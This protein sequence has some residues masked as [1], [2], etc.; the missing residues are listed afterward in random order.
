MRYLRLKI[1]IVE[2]VYFCYTYRVIKVRIDEV[3]EQRGKTR[4]WLAKATSLTQGTIAKLAKGQTTGIDFATLS[5]ICDALSCQTSDVLVA[6]RD[7]NKRK[8]SD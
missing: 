8:D 5:A 2:L 1:C 7:K 4:Y 3:L 6:T